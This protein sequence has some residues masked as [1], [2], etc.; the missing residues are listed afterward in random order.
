MLDEVP[1][2]WLHLTV[3]SIGFTDELPADETDRI[4]TVART[5]IGG[6]APFTMT[7]RP[8][9]LADQGVVLLAAPRGP[10]IEV[11]QAIQK[12]AIDVLGADRLPDQTARF[13]PHVTVAYSNTSGEAAPLQAR[14]AAITPRSVGTTVRAVEL[15]EVSRDTHVYQWQTIAALPFDGSR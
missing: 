13:I 11:Q 8:A 3:Q 2:R 7:L 10:L 5:K 6:L 1:S 12:A 4:A 9:V 14:L 15:L